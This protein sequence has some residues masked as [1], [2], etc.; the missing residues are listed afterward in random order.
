[1][2]EHRR[3][4]RIEAESRNKGTWHGRRAVCRRGE[5]SCPPEQG[6]KKPKV[7]AKARKK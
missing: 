3:L 5:C 7:K 6:G 2:R 4:L 1:M